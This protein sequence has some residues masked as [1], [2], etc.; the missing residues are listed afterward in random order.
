MATGVAAPIGR[1]CENENRIEKDRSSHQAY[2]S[3]AGGVCQA[4][5]GSTAAPEQMGPRSRDS[6]AADPARDSRG[7]G[8]VVGVTIATHERYDC[9]NFPVDKGQLRC[10]FSSMAIRSEKMVKISRN[11]HRIL[12]RI[13]RMQRRPLK[14]VVEILI[15][16]AAKPKTGRA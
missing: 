5:R 14:T 4:Y 11:H 2:R 9:F 1:S 16:E 8:R 3:I 10:I 13:A 6:E 15:D 12:V 7:A